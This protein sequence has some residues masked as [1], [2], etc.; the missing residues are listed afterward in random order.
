MNWFI[1]S[2]KIVCGR[3]PVFEVQYTNKIIYLNIK[4]GCREE[5][6]V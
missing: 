4:S 5:K 3:V 2:A 1:K 6:Y